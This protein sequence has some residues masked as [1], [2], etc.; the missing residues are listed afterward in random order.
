MTSRVLIYGGSGG[1]G[2]ALVSFFKNK[3]WVVTSV[4]TR[5]NSDATHNIIIS[6]DDSLEIQGEKVLKQSNE[7]LKADNA[8]KYDAI[9]CVAG[10]FVMGNLLDKE[11][12]KKSDLMIRKS[13]YSSL[14]ASQLAAHH[15]KEDGFLMLTGT[16]GLQGTPGFI[17]YGVAK[18]G[19]QQ[20]VKSLSAEGSGLP[21]RTRVV[22]LLP[23]TIDTVS[24]RN[25]M[26]RADFSN[27]IP[28]E[29]LTQRLFD[30][31][32]GVVPI[33]NGKSVEVIAKNGK[34]TFNEI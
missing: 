26:P 2:S 33:D 4:G 17:G 29:I 3:K 10:G 32:T 11:F 18:A 5:Q 27:F 20:L 8:E 13:L 23:S 1:L 31:T 12:L 19:T 7:Q 6:V 22:A 24:N 21:K 14:V 15:L 28:L 16:A 30:W 9:L 34:T 25:D